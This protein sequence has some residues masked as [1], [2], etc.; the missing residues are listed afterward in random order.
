MPKTNQLFINQQIDMAKEFLCRNEI[1]RAELICHQLYPMAPHNTDL[2]RCMAMIAENAN[3]LELCKNIWMIIVQLTPEDASAHHSLGVI[4]QRIGVVDQAIKHLMIALQLGMDEKKIYP[5]LF[6]LYFEKRDDEKAL[7]FYFKCP[8]IYSHKTAPHEHVLIL[9]MLR[10]RE[11]SQKSGLYYQM[12]DPEHNYL[13]NIEK[14]GLIQYTVTESFLTCLENIIVIPVNFTIIAEEKYLLYEGFDTNSRGSMLLIN[15]FQHKTEDGRVLVDL[16]R[17]KR[18]IEEEV[19]LFG[20]GPNFSHCVNDWFSKLYV[21]KHFPDLG[22]LPILVSSSVSKPILDLFE[23]FNIPK[24]RIS[25]FKHEEPLVC[26]KA[27]LPSLT[28]AFQFFSPKYLHFFRET[29]Q[30]HAALKPKKHRLYLGRQ[31]AQYRRVTNESAIIALLEQYGFQTIIPEKLSIQE[32]IDLF[33]NAE[34]MVIPTGG[35]SASSIFAP[36]GTVIIDLSNPGIEAY[37]YFI[38]AEIQGLRFHQILGNTEKTNTGK[39]AIDCD[40]NIPIQDLEKILKHYLGNPSV[41]VSES[42]A[43]SNK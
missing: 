28:H 23:F 43:S 39:L 10:V 42:G 37:Q 12:I 13:I 38:A 34:I 35:G 41:P 36:E 3:N 5:Y 11:Y 31:N 30:K 19:I 18:V 1:I 24:N 2:L 27:W 7:E 4:L 29:I 33:A 14:Y 21:L 20:G 17:Q 16:P 15:S 32:Q 22:K 40:F 6:L 8:A 26:K 25:I 9:Q